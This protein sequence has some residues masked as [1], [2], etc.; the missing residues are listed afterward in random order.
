MKKILT[1][2]VLVSLLQSCGRESMTELNTD[3]NSY[4]TT[5]PS[6]VLT[7]AQKQLADYVS[8][9]NVN[10]NN[11]RLTMQY[12]QTTTY[13]DESRY[14][15]S[16]RNVSDQVWNY[17]YVRVIK[18]LEESRKLINN[19]APTA[20]EAST[21][22][23]T[24][25]NQLAIVDL[26]QVYAYQILVDTY[27]DVP[28]TAAGDIEANP[29]PTYDSGAA[30]YAD[31]IKR[32]KDNIAALDTTG[33]SFA[34]GEKFYNGDVAKWKKFGNSLLLKLGIAIADSDAALAQSSVQAA[35]SGGVFT[36]KADDCLLAY[37]ASPNYSALY[38]N[39][40]ASNRNDYVVGKTIVD[41]MNTRNDPRRELY[42]QKNMHYL[43][44]SVVSVTG[45]TVTFTPADPAPAVAPQ[46][47]DNVYVMPNTL[48]GKITSIS[49]N[50]FTLSGY[51]AGTIEPENDLGFSF[52]YKGGTIGNNSSFNSNTR[53]GAFAYAATTPGIIMN[54]TEVA[55][56]LAEASA[57]WGIAGSAAANYATAV[58]ASFAQWLPAGDVAAAS[59]TYL[60]TNPYDAANW[61]KSL[62]EQAW[63]AMYDQPIQSWNFY[64]RLDYPTLAPAANAVANAE[65]K[66]PARLL[67]PVT[68][69]STN[70]TNYGAASTAIGGDKLTTKI[71]WDKF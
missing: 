12:W 34:T 39:L 45:S 33:K 64:R 9:P 44:G 55:F 57:R 22:E 20:S 3:P 36:S 48:V 38:T 60:A 6:S 28:Y 71:F 30:I 65:N 11:L 62:G 26:Q 8:T 70:P 27:G 68:E 41:Y 16:T 46:V 61:K 49:G 37:M 17:L 7:Y 4:Y 53:V 15:F 66:V 67:Y 63:V 56:Y 19:Y 24:K 5:V 32:T 42:F 25:K 52:Y 69:Q 1:S 31:L 50:T 40:V 43:A 13:T 58:T 18:N 35:I 23:K 29:L 21:W 47:G 54:Y 59:A 10:V 14:D 2:I 51:T